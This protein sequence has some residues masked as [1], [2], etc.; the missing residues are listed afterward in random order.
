M[1]PANTL[2]WSF[3]CYTV[4]KTHSSVNYI[5]PFSFP[6]VAAALSVL[7]KNYVNQTKCTGTFKAAVPVVTSSK[8]RRHCHLQKNGDA[9]PVSPL[10][11]KEGMNY[12]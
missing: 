5:L 10:Y 3:L 8:K 2:F 9:N 4:H 1:V 11:P 6:F 7:P 12:H